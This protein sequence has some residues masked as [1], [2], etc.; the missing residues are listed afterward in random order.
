MQVTQLQSILHL[1]SIC[2]TLKMADSSINYQD[3]PLAL[4]TTEVQHTQTTQRPS[5][6]I[7]GACWGLCPC[8]QEV[9][10]DIDVDP[11]KCSIMFQMPF[12]N[13]CLLTSQEDR[14]V[15]YFLGEQ[16]GYPSPGTSAFEEGDPFKPASTSTRR[17]NCCN[18]INDER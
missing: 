9:S 13:T 18:G 2:L 12:V 14:T 1:N 10:I 15:F 17:P 16:L 5:N 7:P 6:Y 4:N 11:N 3:T 8:H